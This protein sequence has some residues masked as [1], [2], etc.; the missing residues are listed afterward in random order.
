M[1]NKQ[2]KT[3]SDILIVDTVKQI[4]ATSYNGKLDFDSITRIDHGVIPLLNSCKSDV[5]SMNGLKSIPID[6]ANEIKDLRK[7]LILDGLT[8]CNDSVLAIIRSDNNYSVSLGGFRNFPAGAAEALGIYK[9]LSLSLGGL[10]SVDIGSAR[11]I[12]SYQGKLILNGLLEINTDVAELLVQ[13]PTEIE[14]NNLE[15]IS[16]DVA[17]VFLSAQMK[18]PFTVN[19]WRIFSTCDNN[20]NIRA[21][22]A[23]NYIRKYDSHYAGP[24][25][26]Y[27]TERYGGPSDINTYI[28]KIF[29]DISVCTIFLNDLSQIDEEVAQ[30][31]SQSNVDSISLNGLKKISDGSALALSNFRGEKLYLNGLTEI[32]LVA[33]KAFS[34]MP[35]IVLLDGLY[36]ADEATK[37][38]IM[39][40][41]VNNIAVSKKFYDENQPILKKVAKKSYLPLVF[42]V[43]LPVLI[44]LV[45]LLGPIAIVIALILSAIGW[46]VDYLNKE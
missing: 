14:V 29:R 46:V 28:A 26:G 5:I 36:H 22:Q 16:D 25:Y 42:I 7:H 17:M 24:Y 13:E 4:L 15:Y 39:L 34:E 41:S 10:R 8:E 44:I 23:C 30:I 40:E 6:I 19:F 43:G 37:D 21:I 12:G 18:R 9:G 2:F 45:V 11:M 35:T 31:L 32:S 27:D 38:F 33:A 20:D 1:K 3:E